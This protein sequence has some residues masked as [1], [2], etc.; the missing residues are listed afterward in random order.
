MEAPLRFPAA[1][2]WGAATAAHQIEGDCRNNH[3]WA[4]EQ[5]GGHI[6]DGS[7]SGIAC[8]HWGR[9]EADADLSAMLGH[10]GQR[11]SIE[12]S[13]IEPAEGQFDAAARNGVLAESHG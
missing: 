9:V 1:F 4:W 7:V 6:A 5:E 10:N 8:D 2:R 13:R 11:L 12:W 3:W